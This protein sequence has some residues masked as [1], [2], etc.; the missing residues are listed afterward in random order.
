MVGIVVFAASSYAMAQDGNRNIAGSEITT[1]TPTYVA[2]ST[3][4]VLQFKTT[5]VSI[6][7]EW[8]EDIHLDF[9]AGVTVVSASKVNPTCK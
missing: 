2:G 8:I 9:P 3:N 7:D 6:D 1:Q 4:A 5:V